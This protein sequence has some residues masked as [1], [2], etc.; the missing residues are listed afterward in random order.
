MSSQ[1]TV[2]SSNRENITDAIKNVLVINCA[3]N[4]PLALTAI[5]GNTLVLHAVWKTPAL[6]SPSMVLLC[7]LA[8]SD[9]AVGAIAQPLF[10]ANNLV[11]LYSQ[12][13][14]LKQILL[15]VYDI[16][17]FSLCGNISLYN[18][19]HK[20]WQANRSSQASTVSKYCHN[21]ASKVPSCGNLDKLCDDNFCKRTLLAAN[22]SASCNCSC[23]MCLSVYVSYFS[24]KN[25]QNCSPS[26]E[27]NS[28]SAPSGW[29]QLWKC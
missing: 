17:G 26:S 10:I 5:I 1:E 7:G 2:F 23:D 20:H 8:L 15:S 13:Q 11:R 22:D 4:L 12:S 16:F 24:C 6:R 9:L 21:S 28:H 25:I 27:C 14:R 3:V 19:R 29:G 18:H